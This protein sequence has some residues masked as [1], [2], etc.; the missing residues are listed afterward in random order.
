LI[1]VDDVNPLSTLAGVLGA[2]AAV[3]GI[4]GL[5]A[6]MFMSPSGSSRVVAMIVGLLGGL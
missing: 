3:L 4:A 2:I 6:S 5:V 1:I